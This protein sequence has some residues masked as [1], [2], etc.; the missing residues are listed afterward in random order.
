MLDVA[1]NKVE[2]LSSVAQSRCSLS[3]N[4]KKNVGTK[5]IHLKQRPYTKKNGFFWFRVY[6]RRFIVLG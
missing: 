6:L 3:Q 4:R 1:W 2:E 5:I